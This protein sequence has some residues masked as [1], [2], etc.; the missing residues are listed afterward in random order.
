VIDGEIAQAQGPYLPEAGWSLPDAIYVFLAGQAT[1]IVAGIVAI[2]LDVSEFSLVA[3]SLVAQ[4]VG[5]L[6]LAV[7]MSSSRGTGDWERDFGLRIRPRHY[8]AIFSGFFLQILVAIV[9]GPLVELFAPEDA[10]RQGVAD[11]AESLDGAAQSLVFLFLVVMVAPLVE[12]VVFRGMLLSRLRRTMG[13]RSWCRREP[14][15]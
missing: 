2:G 7:W 1:A 11:V 6:G 15:P 14:S 13:R 9:V 4:G 5:A 8:W 3:I 12:E 10:P